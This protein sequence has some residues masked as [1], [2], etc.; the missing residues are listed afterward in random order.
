MVNGPLQI[1]KMFP[2]NFLQSLFAK[3]YYCLSFLDIQ[4][5]AII[6]VSSVASVYVFSMLSLGC[7]LIS[8]L[9]VTNLFLHSIPGIYILLYLA[10]PFYTKSVLHEIIFTYQIKHVLC[11]HILKNLLLKEA[12]YI[13]LFISNN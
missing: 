6:N 2:L 10:K 4:Q 9:V 3:L 8:D 5:L 12:T 7:I 1:T 11:L 13:T